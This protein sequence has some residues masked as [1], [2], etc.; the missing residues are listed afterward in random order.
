MDGNKLPVEQR[1]LHSSDLYQTSP[2][3]LENGNG[4]L[5]NA[6][7]HVM[8][9]L[10]RTLKAASL[11]LY[12]DGNNISLKEKSQK[13]L[14]LTGALDLWKSNLPPFLNLDVNSLSDAEW[15]FKQKVVLKMRKITS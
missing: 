10:S 8:V 6:I 9:D 3:L 12:C 13:A 11:D 15:A 2:E 1:L 4:G 5:Q 7:I 14:Q